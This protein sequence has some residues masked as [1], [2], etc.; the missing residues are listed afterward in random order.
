MGAGDRGV[1]I[2]RGFSGLAPMLRRMGVT[3]PVGG[4][5][6][7]RGIRA[8]STTAAVAAVGLA[9]LLGGV[10]L[11]I[12]LQ[13]ALTN[14][15]VQSVTQRAQDVAAQIASDDV[16]AA[17]ATAGASPGDATIVQVID[18]Q[19]A[20][21]VSSPSIDGEPAIIQPSPGLTGVVTVRVPLPFVDG[22]LYEVAATTTATASGP[23]TVL[24]AQSLVAVQ[25]VVATVIVAML[26]A[27]PF[28]LAAVG[29]VTWLAVGRSLTSVDRIRVRVEDIGAA[30]LGERVPVPPASDEIGRLAVTMNHMLERLQAAADRQR[31]F[32]ADASHELKSPLA[33]MRATLDVAKAGGRGVEAQAEAVLSGEV[34]RMTRLVADLLLLARSDEAGAGGRVGEVDV[35]DVVMAEVRRLRAEQIVRVEADVEAVRVRGDDHLIAQAVR[36]LVDNAARFAVS[37]VRLGVHPTAGGVVIVVEDDGPGIPVDRRGEVFDRFVRL[38]DHRARSDGGA[39]LGLA[40][41]GEIA[42][43]HGGSV[44]IDDSG[45]GGAQ[46]VLELADGGSPT[47]SRR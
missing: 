9:L 43:L 27:A 47:G 3:A 19:G 15:I 40:I 5:W 30:D 35:D 21:V 33:S 31:R 8:R 1:R 46:L 20:V 39:G 24:A 26:V 11:A 2:L 4:W 32:V 12:V 10:G 16:D 18:Q 25:R 29:A 36:N 23:V 37:T 17:V 6:S 7:K 45:L 41:V 13:A 42:R 22:D 38:D 28:L 44:R 34:D 14:S